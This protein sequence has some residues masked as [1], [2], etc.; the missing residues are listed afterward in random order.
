MDVVIQEAVGV[1]QA[2]V[3]VFVHINKALVLYNTGLVQ[4]QAR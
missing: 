3:T 4:Y 2:V 1:Y